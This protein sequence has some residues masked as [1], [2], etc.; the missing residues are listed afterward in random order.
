VFTMD[1]R[2]QLQ[3]LLSSIPGVTKV[4]FQPPPSISMT[5]PCIV[6]KRDSASNQHANN[7]SYRNVKRYQVTIMDYDPDS[8]I[9]DAV[10]Q[11]P[12]ANFSQ[13]FTADKLNHDIYT[14]Y[15]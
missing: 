5:Y 1:R 8:S 3:A 2:L 11:L 12:T 6:Y 15:F 4:Y 10:A 13:H 7:L 9:P 14:L